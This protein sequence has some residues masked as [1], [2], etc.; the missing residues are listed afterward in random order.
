MVFAIR[1]AGLSISGTSDLRPC[2]HTTITREWSNKEEIQWVAVLWVKILWWW[3]RRRRRAR[4]LQAV[5]KASVTQIA[6]RYNWGT[7]HVWTD[8][9]L[10]WATTAEDHRFLFYQLR[11]GKAGYTSHRL[12]KIRLLCWVSAVTFGWW[13]QNLTYKTWTNGFILID[14]TG[15]GCCLRLN[16]VGSIFLAHFGPDGIKWALQLPDLSP[17]RCGGTTDAHC[18]ISI[19]TNIWEECLQHLDESVPRRI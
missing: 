7:V 14:V 8:P 11:T 6:A 19:W 10:Q 9:W 12:T 13:D 18:I 5:R 4:L 2:S 17:L 15:L 3:Q 16:G 1:W